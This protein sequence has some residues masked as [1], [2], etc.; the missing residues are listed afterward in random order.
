M[1]KQRI[2]N[3]IFQEI[4]SFAFLINNKSKEQNFNE[5][6]LNFWVTSFC[7][8]KCNYAHLSLI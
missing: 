6:S 5:S 1:L 3:L 4:I 7:F 2:K 8:G